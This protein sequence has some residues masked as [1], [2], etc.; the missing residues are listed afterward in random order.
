[1]T[2]DYEQYY[3]PHDMPDGWTP[4]RSDAWTRLGAVTKADNVMTLLRESGVTPTESMSVLEV[5]CGDGQV[6]AELAHRGL[7]P[8][9]VGAEISHTAA[10]L[11]AQRTEISSVEVFDGRQLPFASGSFGLVLATHVLEH[12]HTPLE[13]LAEIARVAAALV[14]VEVPLE[15][16]LAARRPRARALSARV[17]H[18]QRFDRRQVRELLTAAELVRV[19][20]LSDS[21]PRRMAVFIDGPGRG[22]AKWAVRSALSQL[23]W[24]DRLMTVHYAVLAVK[25]DG[26]RPLTNL[27]VAPQ[28]T[29]PD[30]GGGAV[31]EAPKLR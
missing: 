25:R 6:V 8:E 19:A 17:G 29:H 10:K 16:N 24:G 26:D 22:S 31:D 23:P 21:L 7:G 18:V 28:R 3:A 12:V 2:I 1:M 15:R 27:A 11:A 9:L 4:E 5:G 20:E 13:L 14:I 30:A